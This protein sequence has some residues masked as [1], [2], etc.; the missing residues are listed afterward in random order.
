MGPLPVCMGHLKIRSMMMNRMTWSLA[1]VCFFLLP[2]CSSLMHPKADTFYHQAKG[3]SGKQTAFNLL[4]MMDR[5]AQQAR[6]EIG[7][8]P[9]FQDLHNQ[10]HA[11]HKSLCDFSETQSATTA[12]EHALTLNKELKT[13]FHR[14]DKFKNDTALRAIHLDLFTS[15][16]QEF[17][18][19]LQSIPS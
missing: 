17:R 9:G 7:D 5:S 4:D 6:N 16:L 13:V 15:R 3:D 11:L 2:G 18:A 1:L 8:S 19:I 12:Y 10:F 14:L